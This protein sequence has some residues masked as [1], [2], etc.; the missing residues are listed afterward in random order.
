M[1]RRNRGNSPEGQPP[2]ISQLR[3]RALN[4]RRPL[5]VRCFFLRALS[6]TSSPANLRYPSGSARRRRGQLIRQ[7]CVSLLMTLFIADRVYAKGEKRKLRVF[8]FWRA[9]RSRSWCPVPLSCVAFF[10]SLR[11]RAK[12]SNIGGLGFCPGGWYWPGGSLL[13]STQ[14]F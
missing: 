3:P 2:A 8:L 14:I 13:V 5:Q 4:G 10:D 11:F 7:L 6:V 1:P 9:G 12:E